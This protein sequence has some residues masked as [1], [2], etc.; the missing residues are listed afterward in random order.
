[1]YEDFEFDDCS[2]SYSN[3]IKEIEQ[4]YGVLAVELR[5]LKLDLETL[6]HYGVYKYVY[7]HNKEIIY[8]GYTSASSRKGI[9]ERVE[10]HAKESK[11][12]PFLK[13]TDI[14]F[15]SLRNNVEAKA[16]ESILINQYKPILNTQEIKDSKAVY[17]FTGV[18]DGTWKSYSVI[19]N[20]QEQICK[21]KEYLR[22]LDK[23]LAIIHRVSQDKG[24]G[25]LSI[26]AVKRLLQKNKETDFNHY[27]LQ[28]DIDLLE[29]AEEII[30]YGIHL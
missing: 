22:V 17:D 11:F 28:R 6:T 21:R 13:D 24:D 2:E 10:C 5:F 9:I 14:Y 12:K 7:R 30:K 25:L 29:R 15:I 27:A 18:I 1:M 23:S 16:I 4:V 19:T 20:I 3:D 8:V 26:S